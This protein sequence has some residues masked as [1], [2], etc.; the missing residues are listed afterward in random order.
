M[1]YLTGNAI[2]G[3]NQIILNWFILMDC[4]YEQVSGIYDMAQ[5]ARGRGRGRRVEASMKDKELSMSKPLT[6]RK[7]VEHLITEAAKAYRDGTDEGI[8]KLLKEWKKEI[9]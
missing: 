7:L 3:R 9:K 4:C 8:Q 2:Q 1:A 6:G 5:P